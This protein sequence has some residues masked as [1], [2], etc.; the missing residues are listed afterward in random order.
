MF[1]IAKCDVS[2]PASPSVQEAELPE[3]LNNFPGHKHLSNP[4]PLTTSG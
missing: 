4:N 1:D 3:W 2:S